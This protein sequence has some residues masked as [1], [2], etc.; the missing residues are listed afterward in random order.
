MKKTL[1]CI[2]S[3]LPL[4]LIIFYFLIMII[5]S[6]VMASSQTDSPVF[7]FLGVIFMLQLISTYAV[8]FWI[9]YK[10]CTNPKLTGEHKAVWV[11]LLFF[12]HIIANPVYWFI[13]MRNE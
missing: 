5:N 10:A 6:P 7:I 13:Y 9:I 4:I 12:F 1:S 3:F 2:L 11:V 8:M